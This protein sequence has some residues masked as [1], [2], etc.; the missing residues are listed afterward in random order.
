QA[1]A[2]LRGHCAAWAN[3]SADPPA[4]C[5]PGLDTRAYPDAARWRA[6]HGFRRLYTASAMPMELSTYRTPE[7][8]H[9]LAR[10]RTGQGY[11]TGA[12]TADDLPG[13]IEL[14]AGE[15]AQCLAHAVHEAMLR[16]GR[17]VRVS[18]MSYTA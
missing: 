6:A 10:E 13:V 14:G 17:E 9:L 3:F 5:V 18:I 4:Y 8:V 12:A 15:F 16:H 11:F 2:Q 1:L 7:E